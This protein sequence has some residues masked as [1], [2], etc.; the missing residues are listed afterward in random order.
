MCFEYSIKR[1]SYC[2]WKSY[3]VLLLVTCQIGC[4]MENKL[5]NKKSSK[6]KF[7]S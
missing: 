5:D 4:E 7:Y 3:L 2:C 6:I 1:F